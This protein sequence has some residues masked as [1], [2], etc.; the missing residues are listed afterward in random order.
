MEIRTQPKTLVLTM[1]L[2]LGAL[3]LFGQIAVASEVSGHVIK[4]L[5]Q[6]LDQGFDALDEKISAIVQERHAAEE[7]LKRLAEEYK[8]ENDPLRAKA[9]GADIIAQSA[10]VNNVSIREVDAYIGSLQTFVPIFDQLA[11]EIRQHQG[12]NQDSRALDAYR[13]RF[14]DRIHSSAMVLS[15]LEKY[16]NVKGIDQAQLGAIKKTI[17][18]IYRANRTYS[19]SAGHMNA[20]EIESTR[21][22]YELICAQMFSIKRLLG[23]EKV[24]LKMVT[25][26]E[27]LNVLG[28]KNSVLA[29]KSAGIRKAPLA[30]YDGVEERRNTL[31]LVTQDRTAQDDG[32]ADA[33]AYDATFDKILK[34]EHRY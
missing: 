31:E 9:I 17:A 25:I 22:N 24:Y 7:D 32:D 13:N 26:E 30:F 14:L 5:M 19:K 34:N 12:N 6:R 8:N 33:G 27:L 29:K 18:L 10:H 28:L 23:L 4:N 3:L 21:K 11:R 16:E 15:R 20:D 1:V 2:S